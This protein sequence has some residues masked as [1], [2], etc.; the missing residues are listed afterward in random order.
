MLFSIFF[1][2]NLNRSINVEDITVHLKLSRQNH[3]TFSGYQVICLLALKLFRN[4]PTKFPH[5]FLRIPGSYAAELLH[6]LC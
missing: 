3:I 5:G 1:A 2:L 4:V 6:T